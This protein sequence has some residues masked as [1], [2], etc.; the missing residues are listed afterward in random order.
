MWPEPCAYGVAG[1][2]SWLRIVVRAV[3]ISADCICAGRPVGRACVSRAPAPAACGLAIEVPEMKP[4]SSASYESCAVGGE[5]VHAR[6]GDGRDD[7][8]HGPVGAARREAGHD[9]A[10]RVVERERRAGDGRDVA[11]ARG[12]PGL[13]S[14]AVIEGD[15]DAGQGVLVAE[16][17]V[18]VGRVVD[19]HEAGR[20]LGGDVLDFSTRPLPPR[21]Q[22]T[23]LPAKAASLP[24]VV[25]AERITDRAG[26]R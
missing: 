15:E 16:Q 9:V 7:G 10:A 19:E 23:I 18:A 13:Q 3:V 4:C 2:P 5:D 11:G 17:R 25:L 24:V 1:V 12:Q 26:V 6:G 21:S 20:A 14:L 22:M 8:V